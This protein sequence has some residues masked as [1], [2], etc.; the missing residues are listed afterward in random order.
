MSK[1]FHALRHTKP[2]PVRLSCAPYYTALI[3]SK[4]AAGTAGAVL[5][6]GAAAGN[7]DR[8]A[9]VAALMDAMISA[10]AI[11]AAAAAADHGAGTYT[12]PLL[13]ST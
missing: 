10:L 9:G 2:V 6:A 1:W 5:A 11:A 7:A 3:L 12:R 13:S 4:A 8:A